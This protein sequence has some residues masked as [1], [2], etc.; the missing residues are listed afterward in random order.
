MQTVENNDTC[1]SVKIKEF[2]GQMS[3]CSSY[4]MT[5]LHRVIY[6][7]RQGTPLWNTCLCFSSVLSLIILEVIRTEI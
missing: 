7:G 4:K 5:L 3:H 6:I 2:S 1:G